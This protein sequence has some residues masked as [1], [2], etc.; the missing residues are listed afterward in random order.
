[1][2]KIRKIFM[3]LIM[4][5]AIVLLVSCGKTTATVKI[6]DVTPTRTSIGVTVLVSDKDEQITNTSL[7]AKIYNVD[8]LDLCLDSLTFNED[9][10]VEQTLEFED[11]EKTTK[12]KV[13]ISA[14]V[15]GKKKVFYKKELTTVTIGESEENPIEV[16][17]KADFLKISKDS[18]A[19]YKINNDID[20]GGDTIVPL[21]KSTSTFKGH[22]DGNNK[23]ISNFVQK[24]N[25]QYQ[26]L[27]GYLDKNSSIKDLTILNSEIT[28]SRSSESYVG[29]LAGFSAATITNCNVLDSTIKT[30]GQATYAHYVGGLVGVNVYKIT[31]SSVDN[32]TI[33]S[34]TKKQTTIGG[35]IGSNGGISHSALNGAIIDNCSANTVITSVI[36]LTSKASTEAELFT[37]VGG[38]VGETRVSIKN[39]ISKSKITVT[40]SKYSE[41]SNPKTYE[42]IIGGFAG[43]VINGATIDTIAAVSNISYTTTDVY[44]A[45]IGTLI[46]QVAEGIIKNAVSISYDE[47]NIAVTST[48]SEA[49]LNFT[50]I[51]ETIEVLDGTV[52]SVENVEILVEPITKDGNLVFFG[53]ESS[54]DYSQF[55]ESIKAFIQQNI[56]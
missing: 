27:F 54:C 36:K 52:N 41:E 4:S 19:Y 13:I 39:S 23:T 17:T 31:D 2:S 5:F 14:T 56:Q 34:E 55:P 47:N 9:S 33:D 10:S 16:S 12:Y 49:E 21:F 37:Y 53:Y 43:R 25:T 51:A 40:T 35:F 15:K 30:T 1:M 29:I 18:T 50:F 26:G 46:G 3:S 22:I 11:L 45:L 28:L 48:Y 7:Q 42:A 32:V 44:K 38:F 8:D 24:E 6:V 20:F